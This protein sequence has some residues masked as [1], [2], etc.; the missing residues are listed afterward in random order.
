MAGLSATF[1]LIDEMSDKLDAIASSGERMINQLEGGGSRV[2]ESLDSAI[3]SADG[4]AQSI[5]QATEQTDHWTEA[6]AN[7]NSAALD[8][9]Y[10]TE[11]LVDMG[12]KSAE[13]LEEQEAMFR[14]CEQS[15]SNL[16]S[17]LSTTESIQNDLS[18]SMDLASEIAQ[19]LAD[20]DNVSAEAKEQLAQ[21]SSTAAEAME[22]L[23][24][25][26]REAEAAMAAYNEIISSG[27]TNLDELEAAAQRAGTAAENLAQAN[28]TAKSATE[29]LGKA[30]E[31]A[32][33]QAEDAGG[34][35]IEAIESISSALA[36]A[37]IAA[38]LKEAAQYA[39]E[40]AASFSEAEKTISSATGA[41]GDEL[42]ALESSAYDVY[43]SNDDG[44]DRVAQLTSTV[45][46]RFKETGD[47]LT[48]L[49]NRFLAFDDVCDTDVNAAVTNVTQTLNRWNMET[50]Q[51]D[52]LMDKLT[53]AYQQTGA[54]IS[55]MM[56]TLV[57]GATY[58]QEMDMTLDG[59]ITL[60]SEM[61]QQ[62]INSTQVVTAMRTALTN[63]SADG[64]DAGTALRDVVDQI[65]NMED[66]SEATTLAV[67][68]FGSR[69]GA[70]FADA[71]RNGTISVDTFTASM[72]DADGALDKMA[73][74]T[75]T[76]DEKWQRAANNINSAFTKAVEPA[77]TKMST[78][79]SDFMNGIGDFL[80]ENQGVTKGIVA[81]TTA[82]GTFVGVFTVLGVTINTVIPIIKTLGTAIN[83]SLGPIG[84][85]AMAIGAVTTA[86]GVFCAMSE[87]AESE[88]DSLTASSREQYEE[89]QSLSA[90]Y[91]EAC[92]RFGE[93]SEQALDLKYEMDTLNEEFEANK[94]TAEEFE[95][96]LQNLADA[97]QE[98]KSE[99]DDQIDSINAS[100][101][102]NLAL[103][104][105][106][107]QLASTT[108]KTSGVQEEMRVII[109]QL[110]GSIDG[111]SLSYDDLIFNQDNVVESIKAMAKAQAEQERYEA[112]YDAYVD[113]LGQRT[114][115]N[116]DLTEAIANQEAAQRRLNEAE[117]AYQN[118]SQIGTISEHDNGERYRLREE[119][120]SAQ[121]ALDEAN[122]ALETAQTNLDNIDN[123]IA[124]CEEEF[125][126]LSEVSVEGMND[127]EAAQTAVQEAIDS[128]KSS[129][130]D[131]ITAYNDAYEAAYSS[132]D[133][134]IGLFDT[135]S[136]ECETS[137]ADMIAALQSQSEY[138]N[139]YTENIRKAAEY[140]IDEGLV[141]SLSDGSQESAA[142]LDT[143]IQKIDE[144]GGN[145]QAAK[146]FINEL[147]GS[148]SE[149][150]GAKDTFAGTV[151]EMRTD[152]T[153]EM[154]GI[155]Q[156][157]ETTVENLDLSSEA[158]AAA[159]N[160]IQ[161]YIDGIRSKK[162]EAVAA[163]ESI[164]QATQ[165]ALRTSNQQTIDY[166]DPYSHS[167]GVPGHAEGTTNAEDIFVAGEEGP[168]L[169][170][171]QSGST[172]FPTS[173]TDRIIDAV[174]RYVPLSVQSDGDS[175]GAPSNDKTIRLEING[176]GAM[177]IGDGVN[178]D[179][180]VAI[181]LQNLKPVLM[182]IV[183]E[184]IY[185]EGDGSYEY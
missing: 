92:D 115:A 93:T 65:K 28:G 97:Y 64:L 165:V 88:I 39:Y 107:S 135:M 47:D 55:G 146:D 57:S 105:R 175:L 100:E 161:A 94:K 20:N 158:N 43:A 177:E 118:A 16:S 19:K 52:E 144:L 160:S 138:L 123:E 4:Y 78:G 31:E 23:T 12:L 117:E 116:E 132:V 122:S 32:G 1:R 101:Q 157:M 112:T 128:T 79:M 42:A 124:A 168:E 106:L 44:L 167:S 30:T 67:E 66:S 130:T 17:A 134:T 10:S 108:V 48:D 8:A 114:T 184:E 76:L 103:I 62:G 37:A 56:G 38:T 9:I 129:V 140:G 125:E 109:D 54:S 113:Y 164:V 136:T 7:Y 174:S 34:K 50:D 156:E 91:E 51:A 104:Q 170:V 142:Y 15:A 172:V 127:Q 102:S 182:Q 14:L 153:T 24:S 40:L 63:F 80:N 159:I 49:T 6:A 126:E 33:K 2:G 155:Q 90:E 179:E 110:N 21:A 183:Q 120:D 137:T 148:F 83:T 81:A 87:D 29:Q 185:E 85:V 46:V 70:V 111:L 95:Q 169:I 141:E 84:W 133:G 36:S 35:G 45:S 69:T 61:E 98:T 13:A 149:V 27:T 59:T 150:E 163:A 180:V 96:E 60:L 151:A 71:I 147:N 11:E 152:F 25:A 82:V 77:V 119:R 178:Q 18:S 5:S 145:T 41:V 143:I 181:M 154:D 171:G 75:E 72:D 131:L 26:Q 74:T 53:Y 58:F 176:S 162:G 89:L 121:Q 139:T 3:S 166:Y 173:E 68:T 99:M 86:I 73:D 22:N